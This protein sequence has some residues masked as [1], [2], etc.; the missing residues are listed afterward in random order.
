MKIIRKTALPAFAL[1]SISLALLSTTAQAITFGEGDFR[2]AFN[3]SISVGAS[4]RMEDIDG[5]LVSPGNTGR[6]ANVGASGSTADDGDLNY[7]KGDMYSLVFKGLHDLDL[8]YKNFGV[9]TRFKYWY[10]YALEENDV[11]HGNFPNGYTP[12]SP[13]SDS[14]M[15]N[16]NKFSGIALLDAYFYTS[17]DLGQMPIDLRIGR[18]VV[19]WG[20][21]TFI[22]N[23]VNVINPVD[24]T[25][26]RRPGAE[27]KEALLPV[28]MVY[29]SAG[30]TQ[31]LTVEAFYQFEWARTVVDSCG[32]LFST[33][34]PAPEGCEAIT[35][36]NSFPDQE[37]IGRVD[38]GPFNI[39]GSIYHTD[40]DEP[41]DGNQFGVSFKYFAENLNSTEFGFYF[42]NYH[43][44]TPFL[45]VVNG[46]IEGAPAGA[47]LL[48]PNVQPTYF[49]QFPEDI[50][51][52]GLS[53]NT[54]L[55]GWS[56]GAEVSYRPNMP[57]DIN[58]I[59][60][61]QA[62]ALGQQ[63]P[64]S[65]QLDR[66]VAA[67]NGGIVD[68]YDEVDFT[69][70]QFTLIKQWFQVMGAGSFSF[71]GEFGANWIGDMAQGQNYGRSPTFGKSDFGTL[72]NGQTC[73]TP[74]PLGITPNNVAKNCTDDGYITDFAWGYRLRGVWNYSSV[75]AGINLK[76]QIAWSHDVQGVSPA[77]NF[78][79]GQ[80]ALGLSVTAD[81]NSRYTMDLSY[82]MFFDGDY[83]V[84][85]DRD[86]VAVSFGVSF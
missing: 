73:S 76:P 47:P 83:S 63:A 72:A 16:L 79:E 46:N 21:S 25:A 70:V 34:D 85:S 57:I 4:W 44:R 69:Q 40:D 60:T 30:L 37:L 81:Y 24:V 82:N 52:Y 22:Q 28:G 10:D 6:P 14:G 35:L 26:L 19:S 39:P 15:A 8:S 1:S 45:G 75:F 49:F 59:E 32:T 56:V 71:I 53:F 3:S 12:D 5:D 84:V 54:N 51:V 9:F 33:A 64:W 78:N 65:T 68:G 11:N 55:G 62:I 42:V 18:Q 66:A 50:Q 17:F 29:A 74:S 36:F 23:G 61:L 43:S 67:G 86:F 13:L 77:P 20:E 38:F 31:N 2:G 41:S 27:L 58:T 48:D 80:K 7:D